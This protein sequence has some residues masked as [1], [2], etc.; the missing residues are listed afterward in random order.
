MMSAPDAQTALGPEG[1]LRALPPF[2]SLPTQLLAAT[3]TST[4]VAYVTAG[5]RV[6]SRGGAASEHLYVVRKGTALLSH[7]GIELM[8]VEAGEWFGLASVLG[9]SPPIYDVDAVD[10]LLVYRIPRTVVLRLREDPTF[11]EQ[12]T[13]RLASRLRAAGRLA[14][15]AARSGT[16]LPGAAVSV[17]QDRVHSLLHRELVTLPASASIEEVARTMRDHAISSVI[18][19]DDDEPALVTTSDLRDRVL[20]AGLG[21]DTPAS[22]VASS[23]ILHVAPDTSLTEARVAMLER[24]HHHLGVHDGLRLVGIITT[25]DLLRHDAAS[26]LH[27]QRALAVLPPDGFPRAREQLHAVVRMLHEGGVTAHD[28]TRTVST[29]TDVL[30]RRAI[31]IACERHGP[32][33]TAFAWI[34]LGSDARR[35]QTLLTDQDHALVHDEVDH[36]GAAWFTTLAEEVTSLLEQAGLPR[37]PGG[38]MATRWCAARGTWIGWVEDWLTEPD[39]RALYSTAI[40]LDR[41]VVA[42]SLDVDALHASVRAHHR[43]AVLLARLAA[44]AATAR[45][46]LGLLNRVRAREDGMLDLKLAATTPIVDLA[47]L[48]AMELGT[49]ATATVDRLQLAADAGTISD[50][51]SE[52]L[53]EALGFVQRLRIEAQLD[54]HRRGRPASNDIHVAEL[55]VTRRRHLKEALVAV[56]RIQQLT[57]S[58]LGGDEVAR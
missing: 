31:E 15:P 47:R 37:C 3:I 10:D 18:L 33:P 27:V 28:I 11:A 56:A 6:L 54:A 19:L 24:R 36:H 8:T 5:T 16:E 34:T 57:V 17:P 41:R 40:F 25:G 44:S 22:S 21:P 53:T 29:L 39:V 9:D 51:A 35:E 48:L 13:G 43:D 14:G 1:F 52:E 55:S 32:A 49:S 38:T 7:D 2:A 20:A 12:L 50:E 58:R 23:P 30:V 42:G 45:P 4:E 46:P 26:P